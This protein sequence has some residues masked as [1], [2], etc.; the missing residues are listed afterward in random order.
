MLESVK[1]TG[2]KRV[3]VV[4]GR[5]FG[6]GGALSRAGVPNIGYIPMPSYLVADPANGCIEKLSKDLFHSQ[7]EVFAKVLHKMDGM[8]AAELKGTSG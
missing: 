4:K 8:T 5:Y 2:D 1:G 6:E 7:I 3:A